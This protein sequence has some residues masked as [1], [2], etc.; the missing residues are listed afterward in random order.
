ML[1]QRELEGELGGAV[2]QAFEEQAGQLQAELEKRYCRRP[3][4]ASWCQLTPAASATQCLRFGE[5]HAA[6]EPLLFCKKQVDHFSDQQPMRM[7]PCRLKAWA[8]QL[9]TLVLSEGLSPRIESGALAVQQQQ[10]LPLLLPQQQ[11][12]L[13]LLTTMSGLV[14]WRLHMR[15]LLLMST[16]AWHALAL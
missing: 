10:Q 8:E 9:D 4:G 3:P 2:K 15:Q 5:G 6:S 14:A 1:L 11:Q 13:P 16:S 12:Q 7:S